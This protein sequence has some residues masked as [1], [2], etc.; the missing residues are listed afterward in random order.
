MR[1]RM[2]A[3]HLLWDVSCFVVVIG[4]WLFLIGV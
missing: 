2:D 3:R 1:K 4:A